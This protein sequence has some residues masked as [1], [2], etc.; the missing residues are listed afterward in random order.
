[1]WGICGSWG[2][3][4]CDGGRLSMRIVPEAEGMGGGG[5]CQYVWGG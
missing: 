1:M 2:A 5:G 4:V 3:G